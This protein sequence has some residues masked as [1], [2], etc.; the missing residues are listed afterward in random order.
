MPRT[1]ARAQ[2]E[3]ARSSRKRDQEVVV[4]A[5]KVFYER[6]YANATVQAVADE[7]GILKGSL[8]HY[9]D[10]KEDLLFWVFE[11]VHAD[12]E[13]LLEKVSAAEDIDALERI[14][15]YVRLQVS[16]NLRDLQR[17]AIY[18]HELDRLGPERRA[19]VV[20][21]RRV[22]DRYLTGLIEEAQKAGLADDGMPAA[23]VA[24]CVFATIIWPY[25]WYRGG[26]GRQADDVAD[27]CVAYIMRGIS[28]GF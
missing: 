2:A 22:H 20:K 24:N 16:H 18:Y 13:R 19:S 12:V 14:A 27:A 5:A 23:M 4:A 8:Y 28:G 7:L 1:A 10:T 3:P 26:S 25:R 9:I 15:L 17:M 6:G 11:D 21:W